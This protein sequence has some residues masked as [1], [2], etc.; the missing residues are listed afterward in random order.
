MRARTLLA[1]AAIASVPLLGGGVAWASTTTTGLPSGSIPPAVNAPVQT[2]APSAVAEDSRV[3]TSVDPV[4]GTQVQQEVQQGLQQQ[5][6]PD[7]QSG[8][9]DVASTGAAT[10][11]SAA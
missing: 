2:G 10:T 5:L 4:G 3:Q 7:V 6:G 9:P 8:G 1:S 11:E